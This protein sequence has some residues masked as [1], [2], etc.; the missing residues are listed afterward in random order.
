[1]NAVLR[2]WREGVRGKERRT[3]RLEER[4]ELRLQAIERRMRR[5][6]IPLDDWE[7]RQFI[8]IK[9]GATK[10]IDKDWRPFRV[11]DTWGGPDVSAYFKKSFVIPKE[12]DGK[13]ITMLL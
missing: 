12:L 1:M 9:Q 5:I 4:I 3:F 6:R 11:G 7:I 8:F 2:A 13:P 10:D